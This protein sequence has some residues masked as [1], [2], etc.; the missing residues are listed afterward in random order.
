MFEITPAPSP[1]AVLI[2]EDPFGPKA[3]VEALY[4]KKPDA[5]LLSCV[6]GYKVRVAALRDQDWIKKS[7]RALPPVRA[8][9]FF[10]YGAHDKG[11]VPR[12]RIP[13][14]IEAGMA[15]GTGHHETTALCLKALSELARRRRF[16]HVLDMGC[17]AGVLAIAAAKLW[18]EPVTASDID[19]V[20]VGIT[21]E[22][23]AA[24]GEAAR[25]HAVLASG[26]EDKELRGRGRFDLVLANI[27]SKPLNKLAAPMAKA[28]APGGIAVLSG[29]MRDEEETILRAYGRRGLERVRVMRDGPWS[30]LILSK[31][32]KAPSAR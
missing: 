13:I 21:I 26:F 5:E 2:A 20:A 10:I 27:L 31:P 24:N 11:K 4:A 29:L 17:G 32:R 19:H 23:A 25:V 30:A 1:Q 28:L 3:T 12:G 14:W 18:R 22:N 6:C 16:K 9:R 15:F 8:G 7:Q